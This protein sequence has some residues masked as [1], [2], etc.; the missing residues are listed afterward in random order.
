M[1]PNMAG[2]PSARKK[3]APAPIRRD[4]LAALRMSGMTISKPYLPLEMVAM[5]TDF[6]D[7]TDMVVFARVSRKMH[8]LIY[9]DERWVKRLKAMDVWDEGYEA[10]ERAKEKA[11]KQQ[12][13]R[14]STID[15]HLVNGKGRPAPGISINGEAV[16]VY[17]SPAPAM[18]KPVDR[19][20]IINL[21]EPE[22][23]TGIRTTAETILDIYRNVKSIRTQAR[24]EYGH[25]YKALNKYYKNVLDAAAPERSLIFAS[26]PNPE[27]RARMFTHVRTFARSDFSPGPKA[28]AEVLQSLI[29]RFGTSALLEFRSGY[30]Y[31]DI[32][33]RMK[34]YAQV[35]YIL[36]G[37]QTGVNMFLSENKLLAKKSQFGSVTD[38]VDYSLGYGQLSLERVQAWFDRLGEAYSRE[39]MIIK[40]VFPHAAKVSLL[41]LEKIAEEVLAPFLTALFADAR[42]RSTTIY[43]RVISGSLQ[44]TSKFVQ[45]YALP[46]SADQAIIDRASK[47]LVKLFEPHLQLYLDE[48]LAYFRQ[49][50]DNENNRWDKNR[51]DQ[52]VSTEA[53]LM[54][55][56][57]RSADKKDFM[58]SFKKVIMMPVNILPTFGTKASTLKPE[59]DSM[60]ASRS[61]SPHPRPTSS[62]LP[63]SAPTDVLSAKAAIIT[64]R[65]ASMISLM[66]IEVALN[67]TSY[68]KTSLERAAQFIA[69][70][71]TPGQLARL[72]CS[73]IFIALVHALGDR[74]V[75]S[76]FDKA[77]SHLSAYNPRATSTSPTT[78]AANSVTDQDLFST[79]PLTTFLDLVNTADTI[80]QML[81]ILFEQEILAFK[82]CTC[83]DFTSPILKSKRHF[84]SSLDERVAAGLARGIDVLMEEV[85]YLCSTLQSPN[86]FNP[87]IEVFDADSITSGRAN[88]RLSSFGANDIDI[89]PTAPAVRVIELV[90]RHISLLQGVT[91]KT[92]IDVFIS[93]VSQRLFSA[94]CKHIKRQRISPLG[95]IR[96]L[97]DLTAY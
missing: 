65:L 82:V 46:E 64:T 79:T 87:I 25:I 56:V 35:M 43:L 85:E 54:S 24:Q 9:R 88:K 61:T 58:S 71:G 63:V 47:A 5:I 83:D 11:G 39:S 27:E 80:H 69:L 92:L 78:T 73:S 93:E 4:P 76:G 1:P 91:E 19:F 90:G 81:T 40:T 57:N 41:F 95:A 53:F 32:E 30:E 21:S 6:L 15:R 3:G 37:G 59:I 49:Q 23:P 50:A 33:G 10:R 62:A 70:G 48:E 97:S 18:N 77:I 16:N 36:D 20:D 94:L 17:T 34:Q 84:E 51:S 68:A 74:H 28:R 60:R 45:D 75:H 55:G 44:S 7:A 12:T 2:Q 8:E 13:R 38:C 89:S 26:F 52:A 66:S 86:D 22:A 96:L 31:K 67:L 29:N 42:T 72:T 14:G